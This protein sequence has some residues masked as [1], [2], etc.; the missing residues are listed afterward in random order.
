MIRGRSQ[1]SLRSQKQHGLKDGVNKIANCRDN[2]DEAGISQSSLSKK[3]SN[4]RN[5]KPPKRLIAEEEGPLPI[6]TSQRKKVEV[7]C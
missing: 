7:N 1:L 4:G 6:Q 5:R 3:T 2:D